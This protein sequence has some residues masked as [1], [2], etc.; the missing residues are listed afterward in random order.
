MKQKL[1]NWQVPGKRHYMNTLE[2]TI[3]ELLQKNPEDSEKLPR[4]NNSG[5]RQ[6]HIQDDGRESGSGNIH[7]HS[8]A[9]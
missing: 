8:A 5:H 6:N 1:W 4:A 9:P 3:T 2:R 7:S